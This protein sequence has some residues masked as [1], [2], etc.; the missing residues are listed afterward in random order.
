MKSSRK[1]NNIKNKNKKRSITR[2]LRKK[3]GGMSGVKRQD[4]LNESEAFETFLSNSSCKYMSNGSNGIIL[5]LTIE[6]INIDTSPYLST[7]IDTYGLKVPIILLKIVFIKKSA[8]KATV[9]IEV[10][11]KLKTQFVLATDNEFNEEIDIQKCVYIKTKEYLEPLC[12]TILFD[13][14]LKEDDTKSTFLE[15]IFNSSTA[16]TTTTMIV[17]DIQNNMD[18]F[19]IGIFAMEFA[20]GYS[21]LLKSTGDNFNLYKE[22][23]MFLLLQLALKTGYTHADFHQNNIMINFTSTNYFKTNNSTAQ[24][25]KSYFYHI[26]PEPIIIG[27]PLL[28]DFGLAQKIPES[29]QKLI[30]DLCSS[31]NYTE[32][33]NVLCSVNR[34]DGEHIHDFPGHYGW[35]CGS[36][37]NNATKNEI[38]EEIKTLLRNKVEQNARLN[39]LQTYANNFENLVYQNFRTLLSKDD[40]IKSEINKQINEYFVNNKNIQKQGRSMLDKI[41][42]K[43]QSRETKNEN[44]RKIELEKRPELEKEIIQSLFE[45]YKTKEKIE[46]NK[47]FSSIKQ[48][49]RQ[50]VLKEIGDFK[51]SRFPANTNEHIKILFQ[52][53]RNAEA[54]LTHTFRRNHPDFPRLPLPIENC[55]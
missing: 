18:N 44:Q 21:N 12:P 32:A 25:L 33:L 37:Q 31:D 50:E 27:K 30:Q 26:E 55:E 40:T 1:K 16:D 39:E 15:K 20:D 54:Q 51:N 43:I 4:D 13:D 29:T 6:N 19:D 23:S 10:K 52:Q 53:R 8:D 35:A 46:I 14:I 42:R 2:R 49:L 48:Q 45:D 47:E 3:K 28:V 17:K 41:Q 11:P 5:K 7:D 38:L 36:V 34:K 24:Y 22:M 9:L